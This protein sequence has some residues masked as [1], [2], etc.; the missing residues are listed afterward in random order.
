[1]DDLLKKQANIID[2]RWFGW[3]LKS[4]SLYTTSW[5]GKTSYLQRAHTYVL[6]LYFR[7]KTAQPSSTFSPN[8]WNYCFFLHLSHNGHHFD[9]SNK[10]SRFKMR[11]FHSQCLLW[12]LFLSNFL[13]DDDPREGGDKFEGFWWNCV[14]STTACTVPLTGLYIQ[15]FALKFYEGYPSDYAVPRGSQASF[16]DLDEKCSWALLTW[17]RIHA[18]HR[19]YFDSTFSWAALFPFLSKPSK[20]T[21]QQKN[22]YIGFQA[23]QHIKADAVLLVLHPGSGVLLRPVFTKQPGSVVFPLEPGENRR[24]VVF[25]CEAQGHPPPFYR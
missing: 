7:K 14:K 11:A 18:E 15:V 4:S 2:N 13:L 21:F 24:E 10:D 5:E 8:C 20:P 23:H 12:Q 9:G 22:V 25:S 17:Q 1:M 3:N 6:I 19:I 16:Y